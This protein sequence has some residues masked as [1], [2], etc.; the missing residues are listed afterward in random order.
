MS[1]DG[2]PAESQGDS[3]YTPKTKFTENDIKYISKTFKDMIKGG[4]T[5]STV[6]IEK[7]LKHNTEGKKLL[8]KVTKQQVLRKIKYLRY[9]K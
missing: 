3:L 4:A 8:D 1:Q 7:R 9:E 6:V 5:M 2:S